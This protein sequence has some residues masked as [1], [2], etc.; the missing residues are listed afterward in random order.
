MSSYFAGRNGFGSDRG[1]DKSTK[2]SNYERT[3]GSG[4]M[5]S[6]FMDANAQ[7]EA[8]VEKREKIYNN[9]AQSVAAYAI[10]AN[11]NG[12]SGTKNIMEQLD[13]ML[14]AFSHE[15]KAKIYEKALALVI[16]N[17]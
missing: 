8:E 2:K 12:A 3:S 6:A 10:A 16:V 7:I 13:K 4:G 14:R 5:S 17:I 9:V 11:K 1:T 15:E